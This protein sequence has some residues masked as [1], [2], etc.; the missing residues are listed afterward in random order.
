MGSGIGELYASYL[1]GLNPE[2]HYGSAAGLRPADVF[3]EICWLTEG[4]QSEALAQMEHTI[5]WTRANGAL[6]NGMISYEPMTGNMWGDPLTS[7]LYILH[8]VVPLPLIPELSLQLG[9]IR[10]KEPCGG[11]YGPPDEYFP[12]CCWDLESITVGRSEDFILLTVPSVADDI[13]LTLEE[14]EGGGMAAIDS[15]ENAVSNSVSLDHA[16]TVT[17]VAC[18]AGSAQVKLYDGD[19]VLW[20][21]NIQLRELDP[22]E[23]ILEI[24][25]PTRNSK[26]PSVTKLFKVGESVTLKLRTSTPNPPGVKVSINDD[27]WWPDQGNLTFGDCPGSTGDNVTMGNGDTISVTALLTGN[28]R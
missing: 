9:E 26:E 25:P 5:D 19:T 3:I 15:C 11:N 7:R 14:G 8:L 12:F 4:H 18:T 1:T 13:V 2:A 22:N 6:A 28:G 16:D 10:T 17:L 21:N 24:V 23:P 20:E 27:D